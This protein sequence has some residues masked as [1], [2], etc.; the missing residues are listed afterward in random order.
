M[1]L[2]PYIPVSYIYMFDARN[3]Q[4]QTGGSTASPGRLGARVYAVA[5]R[6]HS[7][8]PNSYAHPC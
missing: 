5:Q 1:V 3:W 8:E 6:Y 2:C 4:E 7:A